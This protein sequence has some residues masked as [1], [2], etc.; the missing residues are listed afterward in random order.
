MTTQPEN[1]EW[2]VCKDVSFSARRRRRRPERLREKR[3]E[4]LRVESS[5]LLSLQD[6]VQICYQYNIAMIITA[7]HRPER[8]VK[9]NPSNTIAHKLNSG[10]GA[11]SRK[12]LCEN[13]RI[14]EAILSGEALEEER[15]D[16]SSPQSAPFAVNSLNRKS[17]LKEELRTSLTSFGRIHRWE[18]LL[19][20]E[21]QEKIGVEM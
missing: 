12:T 3:S 7:N 20:H 6:Q 19:N 11:P 21:H 5:N 1:D 18:L 8:P 15:P 17:K 9:G 4:E 13:H 16:L 10:G 14:D 2:R